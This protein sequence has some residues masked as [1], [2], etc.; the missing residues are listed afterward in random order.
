M[1]ADAPPKL[2]PVRIARALDPF[3]RGLRRVE[4]KLQ[5]PFVSVLDTMTSASVAQGVYVV[6]KI[7]VVD[8]LRGGPQTAETIA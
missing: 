8:A 2:P 6:T 7:G 3:R 5:P 1:P 4:R